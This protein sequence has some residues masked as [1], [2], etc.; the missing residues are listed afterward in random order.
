MDPAS[1][2]RS[3]VDDRLDVRTRDES[4]QCGHLRSGR[5]PSERVY[6]FRLRTLGADHIDTADA[7]F[8]VATSINNDPARREDARSMFV[9][10][11]DV[12]RRKLLP[13]DPKCIATMAG[14][15]WTLG[16]LK[17]YPESL[18]AT[19]NSCRSSGTPEVPTALTKRTSALRAETLAWSG[20]R[21]E[22][23]QTNEEALRIASR[24]GTLGTS[25]FTRSW[26]TCSTC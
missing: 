20:R 25:A 6:N 9:R 24:Q 5:R 26:M 2:P 16:S 1:R 11:L 21:D 10:V 15:A 13:D 18:A 22:A 4:A 3:S 14:L 19:T 12:Y 23:A 7:L 17:R 8:R